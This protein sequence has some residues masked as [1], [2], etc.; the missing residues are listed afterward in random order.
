MLVDVERYHLNLELKHA[1]NMPVI[2]IKKKIVRNM[3]VK[4]CYYA[5]KNM[6]ATC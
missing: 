2:I 1:S 5:V 3:L 6:L 4:S